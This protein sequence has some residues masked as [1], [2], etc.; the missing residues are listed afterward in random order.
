[1]LDALLYPRYYLD[2]ETINFAVPRWAQTS[3]YRTQVTFQW[4]CHVE[5]EPGKIRHEMFLDVSGEDPRRAS[6]ERMI[7]TLGAEGPV[8]VYNQVFEKGRITELAELF[9]DLADELHALNG[10]I[11]DLLPIARAHYCHP[12]M[13]GSWSIKAVLPTVAPDLDYTALTVGNGGDAQEAFRE[14]LHPETQD[15]RRNLLTE[16]LREY[17][18]LDTLAMVRLAWFFQEM[19]DIGKKS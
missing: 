11:V 12:D 8:F 3:P 17:C 2:F 16:G 14:I 7:G 15:E 10:R 13:K 1:M 9:P 5:E 19:S 6:A 18:K 4:S